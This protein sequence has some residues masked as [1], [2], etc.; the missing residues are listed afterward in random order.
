MEME[1]LKERILNA[2]FSG[3]ENAHIRDDYKPAGDMMLNS[4]MESGDYV[5][6]KGFGHGVDSTWRIFKRGYEPY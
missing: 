3:I 6:R 2:G 1:Q 4:L 5:Q